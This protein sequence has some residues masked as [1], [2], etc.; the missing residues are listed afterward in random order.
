MFEVSKIG[1]SA[2]IWATVAIGFLESSYERS[3]IVNGGSVV[4]GAGAIESNQTQTEWSIKRA[5]RTLRTP[6]F[7]GKL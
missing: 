7:D 2:N 5:M 4:S 1:L 6:S 3:D